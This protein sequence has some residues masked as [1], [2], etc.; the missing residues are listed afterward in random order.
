MASNSCR[1]KYYQL[2]FSAPVTEKKA[3]GF[4]FNAAEPQKVVLLLDKVDVVYVNEARRALDRYNKEKYYNQPLEMEIFPYDDNIKMV[5]ISQFSD[6]GAALSY[7]E[8]T[9]SV[10]QAEIF[11]WL[12]KDKWKMILI[13]PTNFEV[14]K[15]QKNL[16]TYLEFLKLSVPGKF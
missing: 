1:Q 2:I 3:L 4:T 16:D 9:R 15:E 13:S 8:K 11:P 14:L 12:P 6:A 7:V 5:M 10:A